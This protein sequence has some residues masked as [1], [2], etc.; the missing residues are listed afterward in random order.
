MAKGMEPEIIP[1]GPRAPHRVKPLGTA[2]V[3]A[4]VLVLLGGGY[5]AARLTTAPAAAKD[6]T[7]SGVATALGN[8]TQ[9]TLSSQQQLTGTIGFKGSYDV[10]NEL[11]GVYT[12]LPSVAQVVREGEV[13]YRVGT[14]GSSSDASVL[15]AQAQLATD[16]ASLDALV[17]P[18]PATQAQVSAAEQRLQADQSRLAADEA[19]QA[20][21]TVTA[22]LSGEVAEVDVSQGQQVQPGTTLLEIVQPDQL[23]VTTS[24]QEIDLPNISVGEGAQV[25]TQNQGTMNAVVTSI[26][27]SAS[28][29]GRQ[30]ALYPVTL[31]IQNLSAG[32]RAGMQATVNF[33]Q[34]YLTTSGSVEF[35][36]PTSVVAQTSGLVTSVVPAVGQN[37]T[38]GETLVTLADSSLAAQISSDRATLA[39]D[40]VQLDSLL[41]PTAPR[42]SEV[43][44]L[45][46]RIASDQAALAQAEAQQA[47]TTQ[48]DLAAVL[49]YG[50]TPAYRSLQQGEGGPDVQELNQALE[51]LGYLNPSALGAQ[52]VYGAATT[53]AVKAMQA[54]LGEPATGQLALGQVVFLPTALRVTSVTPTLGGS[55]GQGQAV[56]AGT[57]DAPEVVAQIDASLQN[58]VKAGEPVSITLPN[59][60]TVSGTVTS[61]VEAPASSTSSTPATDL[62]ITPAKGA[63]LSLLNG[64]S[65]NVA[66]TTQSVQRALAVPVTALLAQP[67]GGYAVELAGPSHR[68]VPVHIGMF[69]DAH[70]LVQITGTSLRPGEKVVVAG[71]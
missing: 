63:D 66:V 2:L 9:G 45:E 44:S 13:L 26:G 32:L 38:L 65:V 31:T 43:K 55:T 17:R 36:N 67:G 30:G 1:G 57:S 40:Q 42:A 23:E 35:T 50:A 56:L 46:A 58:D 3:A 69:D 22:P 34:A 52:D 59:E 11:Q 18:T 24:I 15:Q 48:G 5:V 39:S 54:H 37:V 25:W 60:S 70:G 29:S 28:G 19:S 33:T 20:A 49:L 61:I 68:L 4:A 51:R 27:L 6:G 41:H 62:D 53:A 71:S 21:L 14:E 64:S 7:D 16:Q 10:A 8:V 47:Q 12:E